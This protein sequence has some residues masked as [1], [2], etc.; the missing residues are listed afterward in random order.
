[1]HPQLRKKN[2]CSFGLSLFSCI[3]T[4]VYQLI[5]RSNCA[6]VSI[7]AYY[8]CG[9]SIHSI[10]ESLGETNPLPRPLLGL[11]QSSCISQIKMPIQLLFCSTLEY[12]Y[13]Y[14]MNIM[15]LHTTLWT[16]DTVL[17]LALI[18]HSLVSCCRNRNAD[19]WI[20]MCEIYI[21]SNSIS[22]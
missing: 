13:L 21:P 15:E 20:V 7:N 3:L 19:K 5:V 8:S 9:P 12:Y 18:I 10:P 4:S 11:G 22:W 14:I 16:L 6:S 1:M 17:L 2:I